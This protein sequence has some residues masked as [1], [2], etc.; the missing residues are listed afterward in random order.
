M[1][2]TRCGTIPLLTSGADGCCV[3]ARPPALPADRAALAAR[4]FKALADTTRLTILATLVAN[5][6]PVCACDLGDDV[7][8]GQPTVAHH[9]KVLRDAGLIVAARRGKWAHYRLDPGAASWVRAT[10]A[11]LPDAPTG[12]GR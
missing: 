8:L 5:A 12:G 4:R 10:L 6:D 2:T 9:L 7:A 11:A 3:P 1:D